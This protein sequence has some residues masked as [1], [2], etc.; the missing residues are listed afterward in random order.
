MTTAF[1]F[2]NQFLV[3]SGDVE[4]LKLVKRLDNLVYRLCLVPCEVESHVLHLL[5]L[6]NGLTLIESC[7]LLENRCQF[8]I[9]KDDGLCWLSVEG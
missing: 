2:Y 6:I 5:I 3:L 1:L 7:N 8:R 9:L 4:T